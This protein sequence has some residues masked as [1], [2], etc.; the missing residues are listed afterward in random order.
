LHPRYD[1]NVLRRE[2]VHCKE[3]RSG[4][5]HLSLFT[6]IT[7]TLGIAGVTKTGSDKTGPGI[8]RTLM[9]KAAYHEALR[10]E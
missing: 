3:F 8:L 2:N 10:K 6:N 4:F 9:I 7:L 1:A 5:N